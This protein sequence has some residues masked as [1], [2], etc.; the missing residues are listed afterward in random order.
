M[1][2]YLSYLYLNEDRSDREWWQQWLT[3]VSQ[4]ELL[5]M[6]REGKGK[7]SWWHVA[8]SYP[9]IFWVCFSPGLQT[10]H[11]FIKSLTLFQAFSVLKTLGPLTPQSFHHLLQLLSS[12]LLLSHHQLLAS[13]YLLSSFAMSGSI[14][15]SYMCS[16]QTT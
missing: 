11:Y 10:P 8:P 15:Q 14:P 7:G 2:F 12:S 4:T 9:R 5:E 16:L 3:Y 1:S 13:C 6:L